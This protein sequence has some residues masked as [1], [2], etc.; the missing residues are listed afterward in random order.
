M[1][2]INYIWEP[3]HRL[4]AFPTSAEKG[5]PPNSVKKHQAVHTVDISS[6]GKSHRKA[7]NQTR[8]DITTEPNDRAR[9]NGLIKD[10]KK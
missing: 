2:F 5:L 3:G 4:N 8:N 7:G 9:K 1:C 10:E 6:R